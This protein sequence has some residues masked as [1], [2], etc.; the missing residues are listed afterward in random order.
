MKLFIRIKRYRSVLKEIALWLCAIALFFVGY[1][2]SD[3]CMAPEISD[4]QY[5]VCKQLVNDIYLNKDKVTIEIPSNMY[6]AERKMQVGFYKHLGY[7]K[8]SYESGKL[9]INRVYET[10][11]IIGRN[12]FIGIIFIILGVCIK[13]VLVY[14]YERFKGYGL[15]E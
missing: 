14:F 10:E 9:I 12:I 7:A 3:K 1:I 11:L 2:Y 5:E 4:E 8:A 6:F 15:R 13:F